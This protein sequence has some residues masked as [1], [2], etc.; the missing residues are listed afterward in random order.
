MAA[1]PMRQARELI[2]AKRYAEA[3]AILITVD[4]PRA[5]QWLERI[6]NLAPS[7][8]QHPVVTESA[9]NER[10]L[11][12]ESPVPVESNATPPV[13]LLMAIMGGVVGAVVGGIIWALIAI[14]TDYEIG[15]IAIG[16]GA[17]A[18]GG[19]LIATNRQRGT[20]F[21]I[22][23]V[24]TGVAGIFVGKLLG[25]VYFYREILIEDY[26]IE[27]VNEVGMGAIIGDTIQLFPEYL[28]VT[29][30]PIDLLFVV[31]AIVTAWRMLSLR[32]EQPATQAPVGE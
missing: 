9:A 10:F 32:R 1:E 2:K 31:L 13:N 30:E 21:Q 16:V 19:V 7:A 3:R 8:S 17:L 6:D 11:A 25:A 18:G 4:D 23:A 29:L 12:N 27:L 20:P 28:S 15:Y 5:E 22:I 26:G 24:M 14:I